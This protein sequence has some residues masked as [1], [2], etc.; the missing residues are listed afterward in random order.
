MIIT[1]LPHARAYV[2]EVS[3][4]DMHLTGNP[5]W[6]RTIESNIRTFINRSFA[7]PPTDAAHDPSPF[8][9]G[10]PTPY[11]QLVI[12]RLTHSSTIQIIDRVPPSHRLVIADGL[13]TD[14]PGII[15]S[16]N[17]ADCF[18]L[19]LSAP[20]AIAI[21]HVG[22]RGAAARLPHLIARELASFAG[23]PPSQISA[24]I[25]PGILECCFEVQNDVID[26]FPEDAD[27]AVSNVIAPPMNHRFHFDLRQ[28]I[29]RQLIR[30]EVGTISK[31]KRC[32]RCNRQSG[33][34]DGSPVT[35]DLPDL[36]QFHSYR[37]EVARNSDQ[38]AQHIAAISLN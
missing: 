26:R 28:Q 3:D 34:W 24:H 8:P 2:S 32:T 1:S 4:R 9:P 7:P 27:L 38:H 35:T 21:A 5:E 36:P 29:V 31:S 23:V 25:G 17:G 30:A 14:R 6:D 11:E 20:H 33:V 19:F 15:L 16:V 18:P 22:W 37:R 13:M 12:P 10:S